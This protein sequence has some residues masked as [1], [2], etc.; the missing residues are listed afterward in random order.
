MEAGG[1]SC[2]LSLSKN[3]GSYVTTLWDATS[4]CRTRGLSGFLSQGRGERGSARQ[5]K[6]RKT[7][8]L[9]LGQPLLLAVT[10]LEPGPE[11]RLCTGGGRR[12]GT[13]AQFPRTDPGNDW[14]A[15]PPGE[16]GDWRLGTASQTSNRVARKASLGW[17]L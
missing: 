9:E 1:R 12:G 11:R 7:R 13:A 17:G 8:A 5:P 14:Q 15:L 4:T 16:S 10:W 6:S 3:R 2:S